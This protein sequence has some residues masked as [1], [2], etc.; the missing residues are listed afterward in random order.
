MTLVRT[1]TGRRLRFVVHPV[2]VPAWMLRG[3]ACGSVVWWIWGDVLGGPLGWRLRVTEGRIAWLQ[4]RIHRERFDSMESALSRNH[5][6]IEAL[7]ERVPDGHARHG[8]VPRALRS[9]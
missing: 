3:S 1:R 8:E 5:A 4:R 9:L 7:V 6:L 2:G